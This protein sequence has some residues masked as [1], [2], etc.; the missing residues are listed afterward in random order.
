MRRVMIAQQIAISRERTW[1]FAGAL[2]I[3]L[4]AATKRPVALAPAVPL[5]IVTGYTYDMGYGTKAN[6]NHYYHLQTILSIS[7][8][9]I[10][11][12]TINSRRHNLSIIHQCHKTH[13]THSFV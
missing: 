7:H 5:A 12:N 10:T 11:G 6:M 9:P 2:T 1:W 4:L 8:I 13:Q 3:A